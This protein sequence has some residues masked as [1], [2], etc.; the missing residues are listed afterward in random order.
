MEH[1][2]SAPVLTNEDYNLPC[3]GVGDTGPAA[4]V[5]HGPFAKDKGTFSSRINQI[6]RQAEKVP[7][8]GK[9]VAHEDWTINKKPN[10]TKGERTYKPMNKVPDPTHYERKDFFEQVGN[11]GK[12][13]LSHIPRVLGGK[14]PKGKRRSMTDMAVRAHAHVPPPGCYNVA[15]GMFSDR[16][17]PHVTGTTSWQREMAVHV[18]RGQPEPYSLA[19]SHYTINDTPTYERHAVY[20]VPKEKAANFL[21]KAVKEKLVDIKNKK[22]MPGPGT[23][24]QK[25]DFDDR[26]LTRGT[27]MLQLRGLTRS[28]ASGYF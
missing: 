25:T 20:S 1:A 12:D 8:P 15:S 16:L 5:Q 18:G 13:C 21:D 9:Y 4:R 22:E 10:W 14:I 2:S 27:K 26:K 6:I 11:G 3:H 24:W 19:P 7:G 17:A 23:Y 28:A